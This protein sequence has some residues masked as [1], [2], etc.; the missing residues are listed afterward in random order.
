LFEKKIEQAQT[1]LSNLTIPLLN[2]YPAFIGSLNK[3]KQNYHFL[4]VISSDKENDKF[5]L[6]QEMC[7]DFINANKTDL[8]GNKDFNF[9]L[10]QVKS[11]LNSQNEDI[12][13]L[14]S[15]IDIDLAK[16]N[17][18]T[19]SYLDFELAPINRIGKRLNVEDLNFIAEL[20]EQKS[21]L[22]RGIPL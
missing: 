12:A 19:K 5:Q 18:D 16:F 20:I 3:T 6:D 2:K 8:E 11:I 17:F 1:G 21:A 22:K 14:S 15:K 10:H 9:Y 4:E 13:S 7:I